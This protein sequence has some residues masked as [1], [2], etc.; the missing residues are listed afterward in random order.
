MDIARQIA[1]QI[2]T[3]IA[4]VVLLIAAIGKAGREKGAILLLS[5]AILLC[6]L[7]VAG[8]L[9]YAVIM[10]RVLDAIGSDNVHDIYMTLGFVLNILWAAAIVLIAVG[11]MSRPPAVSGHRPLHAYYPGQEVPPYPGQQDTAPKP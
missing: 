4:S 11:I 10:P 6:L 1:I 3:L 9:L 7:A 8:P 2:P 5:G